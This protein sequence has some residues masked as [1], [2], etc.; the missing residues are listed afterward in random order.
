MI[1]S[2]ELV[3]EIHNHDP[4]RII[5]I[6]LVT[7]LGLYEKLTNLPIAIA[8]YI[9]TALILINKDKKQV[10]KYAVLISLVFI[11]Y[12]IYMSKNFIQFRQSIEAQTLGYS[13]N[14]IIVIE[15]FY[16]FIFNQNYTLTS[17][18][19]KKIS[20]IYP[21]ITCLIIVLAFLL[22]IFIG[23]KQKY[24][25][26]SL[27]IVLVSFLTLL[28]YPFFN[29][30]YRPW[31]FY[32]FTSLLQIPIIYLS[33]VKINSYINLKKLLILL[34]LLL[35]IVN[36]KTIFGN[37]YQKDRARP[38]NQE[39][40]KTANQVKKLPTKNIVC[41]D[42]SVCYNII[43]ATNKDYKLLAEYSFV[44]KV[45]ICKNIES[46]KEHEYLLITHNI[47]DQ[48]AFS[49]GEKDF[50]YERSTFFNEKCS[51]SSLELKTIENAASV[52]YSIYLHRK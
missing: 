36:L 8:I 29:G 2:I 27:V 12:L 19:A 41:L 39:L 11:P 10:I 48:T 33:S 4:K 14:L 51:T 18:F 32:A 24:K 43:M 25:Y 7:S 20:V 17:L 9:S 5:L 34:I 38:F 50:L 21:V 52:E 37:I 15:N 6:I 26:Q 22:S 30:L 49:F 31:H 45:D 28:T 35:A 46:L 1:A 40:L 23:T 44:N 16:E 13:K 3:K 47:L 42:Y